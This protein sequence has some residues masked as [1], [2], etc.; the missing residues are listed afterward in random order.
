MHQVDLVCG[1]K[2]Q[3]AIPT[4][5]EIGGRNFLFFFNFVM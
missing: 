5:Q 1:H 3:F 2:L 4:S